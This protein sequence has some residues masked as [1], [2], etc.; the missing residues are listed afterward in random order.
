MP[1]KHL[2]AR[3]ELLSPDQLLELRSPTGRDQAAAIARLQRWGSALLRYF[4][5]SQEPRISVQQDSEGQPVF[6]I[7]DPVD[8]SR[9]TLTSEQDVRVWLEK[10]Y[11]Q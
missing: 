9:H 5:G 1:S 4:T 8:Q 11:Y 6:E 3:L 2:Y 7:Y 10:R